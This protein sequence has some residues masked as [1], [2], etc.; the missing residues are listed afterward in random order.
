MLLRVLAGA[1]S[2]RVLRGVLAKVLFMLFSFM[3][4]S[5]RT[6]ASTP[7]ARRFWR[8]PLRAHSQA[9]LCLPIHEVLYPNTD[10]QKRVQKVFWANGAKELLHWYKKRVA[11]VQNRVWVVQKTLGRPLLPWVKTPLAPSPSHL[12]EISIVGPSPG[13][14][15]LQFWTLEI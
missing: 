6:P 11:P 12:W 15:G 10:G 13:P 9:L 2:K 5:I 7:R 8:A 14:S 3:D 1:L 4:D